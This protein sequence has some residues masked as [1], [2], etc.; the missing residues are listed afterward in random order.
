MVVSKGVVV[1]DLWIEDVVLL[2][3]VEMSTVASEAEVEK[4]VGTESTVVPEAVWEA[5]VV[6]ETVV[7]SLVIL[8]WAQMCSWKMWCSQ[9]L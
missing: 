9:K 7:I 2:E 5:M 4:L 6:S 8:W 3:A 1:T